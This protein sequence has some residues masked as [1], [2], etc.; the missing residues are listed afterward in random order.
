MRKAVIYMLISVLGFSLMNLTVKYL[1]RLPATELV[2]FRSIVSLFLSFYFLRRRNIS[3]WGN[4]KGYLLGRGF[5][6]KSKKIVP[7]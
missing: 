6:D 3:P 5:I 1:D 4:Q 7:L 2:L